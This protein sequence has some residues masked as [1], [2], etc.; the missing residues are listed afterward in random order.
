MWTA[1]GACGVRS[2]LGGCEVGRR[3]SISQWT[4]GA[5]VS[6]WTSNSNGL[7]CPIEL[8]HCAH[9]LGSPRRSGFQRTYELLRSTV[10][11]PWHYRASVDPSFQAEDRRH[12]SENRSAGRFGEGNRRCHVVP[13]GHRHRD[14]HVPLAATRPCWGMIV[15]LAQKAAR[16]D[17]ICTQPVINLPGRP[18]APS[19]RSERGPWPG[20]SCA[21][22]GIRT[23]NLLIRSQMLYPL[24]YGRVIFSCGSARL[25]C[26]CAEA[27]GFEPGM[28]GNPKPH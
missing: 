10:D 25:G 14:P 21:P 26:A 22:E 8:V 12:R 2:R 20:L 11:G 17:R 15:G 9:I 13:R 3:A 23:P 6:K 28:G 4:S 7:S 19:H 24:S 5:E 27:P 16:C 1:H 18:L